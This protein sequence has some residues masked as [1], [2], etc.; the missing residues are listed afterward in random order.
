MNKKKGFTLLEVII[1]L[2][3]FSMVSIVS[4]DT[5]INGFRTEQR[6]SL[7]NK[8]MQDARL[9][10]NLI[11]QEISQSQID[12]DEYFN[13]CVILGACPIENFETG[14]LDE[15]E[16]LFY[17]QNHGYYSWQFY[18]GGYTSEDE[19]AED[20]FGSLCE[21]TPDARVRLP[22]DNCSIPLG[23][24]EDS[25]TGV[26]PAN[27]DLTD[28]SGVNQASAFCAN[29]NFKLFGT[30]ENLIEEVLRHSSQQTC[31]GPLPRVFS[32]LYLLNSSSNR[33]IIL[34]RGQL[35]DAEGV[36]NYAVKRIELEPID[37]ETD[38][39]TNYPVT[40]Y[41]CASEYSC[42]GRTD[43][44]V[45][46]DDGVVLEEEVNVLPRNALYTE[47]TNIYH[48][49]VPISPLSVNVVDLRF[50]ITPEEDPYRAYRE[51]GLGHPKVTI[52]LEVEP[53]TRF[54]MPFF[55]DR[56][57]LKLQ[58]TVATATP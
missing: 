35:G 47:T 19:T 55:S 40:I 44:V 34:G 11:S 32:E 23:F 9:I 20:G 14:E 1:V 51:V 15:D 38:E 33:K 22:D 46:T 13:Q 30:N 18:H 10:L 6:A 31:S 24:S 4:V 41:G 26:N 5:Y 53:S 56:F 57:N 21:I 16:N 37:I 36:S 17:G 29:N 8:V 27:N 12:Y 3:I 50:I 7:Q 25:N 48:N 2:G 28:T 58:T 45:T 49:L 54:R 39:N 42:T 52:I 43:E